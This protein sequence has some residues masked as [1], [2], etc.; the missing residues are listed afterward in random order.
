MPRHLCERPAIRRTR[1][2]IR[3]FGHSG[4]YRFFR[5]DDSQER[6]WPSRQHAFTRSI[7]SSQCMDLPHSPRHEHGHD[8]FRANVVGQRIDGDKMYPKEQ[9][10]PTEEQRL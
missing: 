10:N 4:H 5:S 7:P 6:V 9:H 1:A 3:S 8:V 2:L